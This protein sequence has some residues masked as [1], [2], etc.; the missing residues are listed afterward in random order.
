MVLALGGASQPLPFPG[1]DRPG[2]YAARGLL[3][4]HARC[5]LTLGAAKSESEGGARPLGE[6]F[7][8]QVCLRRS[9]RAVEWHN[10]P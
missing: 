5:G 7:V 1:V 4:L 8:S 6:W 9:L 10:N 3:M 2:V